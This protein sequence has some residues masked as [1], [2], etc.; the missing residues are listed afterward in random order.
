MAQKQ[1]DVTGHNIANA[2]TVGFT[3]QRI[4]QQAIDP[5]SVSTRLKEMENGNVGA[6]VLTHSLD[7]IRDQYLDRRIRNQNSQTANWADRYDGLYEIESL[8]NGQLGASNTSLIK[9]T[10]DFFNA[11]DNL[12]GTKK[13]GDREMRTNLVVAAGQLTDAVGDI[14][15]KLLELQNEH[16]TIVAEPSA[17]MVAKVNEL[18]RTIG[19]YNKQ[20]FAFEVNN[21]RG[22]GMPTEKALDLRDQRNLLLD[23]LSTLID[24]DY[25]EDAD[26]KLHVSVAGFE[27]VNHDAVNQLQLRKSVDNPVTGEQDA[28]SAVCWVPLNSTD[29]N[30]Y[31]ELNLSGGRI[32]AHLDL[33]DGL[34]ADPVNGINSIKGIPQIVEELNRFVRTLAEQFNAL[35]ETGWTYP[36]TEAG[37]S[38]VSHQGVMFF[39]GPRD[40]SGDLILDENGKVDYSKLTIGNFNLNAAIDPDQGGSVYNIA[41]S[42]KQLDIDDPDLE[43]SNNE[44]GLKLKELLY[45]DI[46]GIGTLNG[47]VNTFI[48]TIGTETNVAKS[49][50]TEYEGLS[51][52]LE[53]MFM[54]YSGVS[55]DE[56]MTNLIRFNHAFTAASRVI[57]TIDEQLDQ[58]INRMG[59]VGL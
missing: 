34:T 53:Q 38:T 44:I 37:A 12:T 40:D 17:G 3:R 23:E 31:I 2:D 48:L 8:F 41:L 20:I 10:A 7:Q 45:K 55:Q 58:I 43:Q 28:L 21:Y 27:M 24:M 39:D 4:V 56:E 32:K 22:D 14:Y 13:S 59:R 30:A 49:R 57:T 25:Y 47:F 5:Y 42:S 54:S 36:H 50:N 33:R 51:Y 16:E 35:H 9:L 19:D 1:M 18:L 46:P 15:S 29:P 11:V 6:G 26:M 52:E